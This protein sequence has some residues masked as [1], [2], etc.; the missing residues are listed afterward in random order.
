[1]WGQIPWQD[2]LVFKHPYILGSLIYVLDLK[3]KAESLPIYESFT[4][5]IKQ[6]V[7]G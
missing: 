4:R 7:K 1:M 2:S 6:A 3:I 5:V